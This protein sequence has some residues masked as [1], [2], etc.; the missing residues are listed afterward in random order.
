MAAIIVI[1]G[2]PHNNQEMLVEVLQDRIETQSGREVI[3]RDFRSWDFEG[4]HLVNIIFDLSRVDVGCVIYN[5]GFFGHFI[6]DRYDG[7]NRLPTSSS[8]ILR[9]LYSYNVTSKWVVLGDWAEWFMS[10]PQKTAEMR[11]HPRAI[12]NTFSSLANMWDWNIIHEVDRENVDFW[13]DDVVSSFV[14]GLYP[15]GF[16][17]DYRPSVIIA[18]QRAYADSGLFYPPF[19]FGLQRSPDLVRMMFEHERPLMLATSVDTDISFIKNY[20]VPVIA[21]DSYSYN[22]IHK[23]TGLSPIQLNLPATYPSR[24]YTDVINNFNENSSKYIENQKFDFD[25]SWLDEEE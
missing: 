12:T 23:V 13:A 9:W 19:C 6:M 16:R 25:M 15:P 21:F 20:H 5:G 4:E 24:Q 11:F 18:E 7:G 14:D 1:D 2:P 22:L 8:S 17:G 3:V 10:D